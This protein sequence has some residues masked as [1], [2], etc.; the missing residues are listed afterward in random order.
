MM[1]LFE[2]F[3][4]FLARETNVKRR[5]LR[6]ARAAR[7]DIVSRYLFTNPSVLN[8]FFIDHRNVVVR[9]PCRAV[10]FTGG[11]G[12]GGK[13]TIVPE[14]GMTIPGKSAQPRRDRCLRFSRLRTL[15][16]VVD[17]DVWGS[18]FLF[19]VVQYGPVVR[20]PLLSARWP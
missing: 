16:A 18:R 2:R 10:D 12:G 15:G 13:Q 6:S 11:E 3:L 14:G 7:A 5:V 4:C 8:T 1:K 19:S 17:T 9:C 20:S